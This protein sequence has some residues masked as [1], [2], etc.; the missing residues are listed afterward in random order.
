MQIFYNLN[1]CWWNHRYKYWHEVSNAFQK[2]AS[3]C[4][5]QF[6]CIDFSVW[7]LPIEIWSEIDFTAT[8][9]IDQSCACVCGSRKGHVSCIVP[10]CDLTGKP[11]DTLR[12]GVTEFH[13][14]SPEFDIKIKWFHSSTFITLRTSLSC[15]SNQPCI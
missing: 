11:M 10:R 14:T 13:H 5:Y 8:V 3:L 15:R 1:I 12:E 2:W 7:H 6:R 9:D 4:Q